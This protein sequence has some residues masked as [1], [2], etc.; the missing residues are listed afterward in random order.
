MARKY[1]VRKKHRPLFCFFKRIARIFIHEPRM[2]NL[3]GKP[4]MKNAVYLMNHSG[5][6]GPLIF[7]LYFPVFSVPWGAHEM[8]G[9]YR[10]RWCYLYYV[11]YQQKMHWKKPKAFIIATLFAIISKYLY[12]SVGLIGTYQNANMTSAIHKSIDVLNEDLSIVIFPEDSRE[13]YMDMPPAFNKG[14]I[15]LC[16][17]YFRRTGVD[18]P[19]Y[20][21]YY[22]KPKNTFVVESPLYVNRLLSEGKSDDEVAD[23]Y[24]HRC[25]RLY[26]DYIAEEEKPADGEK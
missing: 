22:S 20:S 6:R 5:A 3:T 25:H 2:I 12:T 18:L 1:K 21:V 19:V 11:F 24:L 16:K 10:E 8:C 14:F 26:L 23:I 17:T 13:G 7:Q 15:T 9:N 4:P